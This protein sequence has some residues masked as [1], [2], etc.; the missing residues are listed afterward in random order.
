[1]KPWIVKRL[2]TIHG[3]TRED[4]SNKRRRKLPIQSAQP[5]NYRKPEPPRTVAKGDCWSD[6]QW[7]RNSDGIAARMLNNTSWGTDIELHTLASLLEVTI[8]VFIEV[9]E[10]HK[11]VPYHPKTAD[12]LSRSNIYIYS[13]NIYIY[14]RSIT[15]MNIL[16]QLQK[17][18]CF[19]LTSAGRL[20]R[21]SLRRLK[22][23]YNLVLVSFILQFF[24]L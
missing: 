24:V 9:G 12:A 18:E 10:N 1:M 23:E 6:V 17:F 19:T 15:R 11:W 21:A 22:E 7:E 13:I 16:I 20:T 2:F 5:R 8:F 14:I 4:C 3:E